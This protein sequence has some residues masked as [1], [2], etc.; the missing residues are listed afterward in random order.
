MLYEKKPRK[1]FEKYKNL[2][3]MTLYFWFLKTRTVN[4]L[5]NWTK[6]IHLKSELTR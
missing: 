3:K 6:S 4:K 2:Y 5:M 1:K